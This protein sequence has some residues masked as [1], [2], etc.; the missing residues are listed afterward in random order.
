MNTVTITIP[1]VLIIMAAL[2]FVVAVGNFAVMKA[3]AQLNPILDPNSQAYYHAC[4][5]QQPRGTHA[6]F[7]YPALP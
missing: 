6:A 4:V 7:C 2:V 3:F 5:Y 1:I